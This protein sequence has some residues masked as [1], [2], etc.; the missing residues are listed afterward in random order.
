MF[1]DGAAFGNG[2]HSGSFERGAQEYPRTAVP[3][4]F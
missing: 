2:R 3:T 4:E 1:P